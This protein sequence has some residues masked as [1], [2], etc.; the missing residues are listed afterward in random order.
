VVGW[1]GN[2]GGLG[3]LRPVRCF[4]SLLVV[5]AMYVMV[6]SYVPSEEMVVVI[7][8]VAAPSRWVPR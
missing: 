3:H 6:E 8:T 1:R 4:E 5:L 2:E 7:E